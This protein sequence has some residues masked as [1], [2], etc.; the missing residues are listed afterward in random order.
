MIL[1]IL[2]DPG[3]APLR[4]WFLIIVINVIIGIWMAGLCRGFVTRFVL[5][6][7]AFLEIEGRRTTWTAFLSFGVETSPRWTSSYV[8][9]IPGRTFVGLHNKFFWLFGN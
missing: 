2:E 4:R 5:V 3:L 6:I 9:V 1:K 8:L 7:F